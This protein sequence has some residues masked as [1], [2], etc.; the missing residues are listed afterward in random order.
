MGLSGREVHT[1]RADPVQVRRRAGHA[2]DG[3][4]RRRQ[5][6]ERHLRLRDRR[7]QRDHLRGGRQP[8]QRVGVLVDPLE[9]RRLRLGGHEGRRDPAV[10]DLLRA[11]LR[12]RELGAVVVVLHGVDALAL[13]LGEQD[14][15]HRLLELGRTGRRARGDDPC[16]TRRRGRREQRAREPS[17]PQD[18]PPCE[19]G[20]PLQPAENLVGAHV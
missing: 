19:A 3:L 9:E 13:G 4:D 11:E 8:D 20:H 6:E 1:E 15:G 17:N 14:D 2:V 10:G 12:G 7:R 18:L 16:H 5:G